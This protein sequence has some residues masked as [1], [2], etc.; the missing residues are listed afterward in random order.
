MSSINEKRYL[1]FLPFNP[2]KLFAN[3]NL[4]FYLNHSFDDIS[5][6]DSAVNNPTQ[7]IITKQ[8]IIDTSK[9]FNRRINLTITAV[10]TGSIVDLIEKDIDELSKYLNSITLT[11]LKDI[12]LS[13][14]KLINESEVILR[15]K[16]GN[17]LSTSFIEALSADM[18]YGNELFGDIP[19]RF[20]YKKNNKLYDIWIKAYSKNR[21]PILIEKQMKKILK[22]IYYKNKFPDIFTPEI[23]K[24]LSF[25]IAFKRRI[26]SK[27]V[28][29]Y[30]QL[31]PNDAIIAISDNSYETLFFLYQSL[32][33][34]GTI[35]FHDYGFF[36]LE[37][38]HLINNFLD[39]NNTDNPFVRNYYGEFTTDPSFD[40]TYYKLKDYVSKI[41]IKKTSERVAKITNVPEALINL[42]GQERD[43]TF[44][45][46]LI[47]ERFDVW[48]IE[49]QNGIEKIIN[50]YILD[51]KNNIK[52]DIKE[53]VS[54]INSEVKNFINDEHQLTIE[55]I[56]LGYF[57]D[58]D[59][60]F[61][62]IEINK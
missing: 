29:Y 52:L 57:N 19:N 42:D 43:T 58:D 25:D 47:K 13:R 6:L 45:V 10:G 55:K 18:F 31:Y 21:L 33:E 53:I 27:E 22:K 30:Y 8:T 36:S 56:L 23:G 26:F 54:Q 24:I 15:K 61:L 32:K 46:G 50:K 62:T 5:S 51:L 39:K 37:N 49:Y 17:I 9:R 28:E 59:Q 40:Y 3:W 7:F 48:N 41:S 2:K 34:K 14:W 60:R 12:D 38:L 4:Q 44:F 16:I 11:D 35:L 1:N 20:I